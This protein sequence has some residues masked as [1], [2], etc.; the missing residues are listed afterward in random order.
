ME[1]KTELRSWGHTLGTCRTLSLYPCYCHP[2][3]AL[4]LVTLTAGLLTSYATPKRSLTL[5]AL[6]ATL[7]ISE[8]GVV[9][10]DCLSPRFKPGQVPG[11]GCSDPFSFHHRNQSPDAE[12]PGKMNIHCVCW[13]CLRLPFPSF[14]ICTFFPF[15]LKKSSP[16][17]EGIGTSLNTLK[18]LKCTFYFYAFC[19]FTFI[20]HWMLHI[21]CG[22][23]SLGVSPL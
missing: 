16:V 23:L 11:K 17:F 18:F 19:P 21:N 4:F 22:T 8:Q 12:Q 3:T 7:Q 13:G 14:G 5:P 6:C 10:S 2:W 20:S 1:G 15:A 9:A